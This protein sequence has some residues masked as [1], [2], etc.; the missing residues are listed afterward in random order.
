MGPQSLSSALHLFPSCLPGPYPLDV[1]EC[2]VSLGDAATCDHYCH[3]YLGG[4]YCSCRAGYVL[5][6]NKHTCSGEGE[7]HPICTRF[8]QL[9]KQELGSSVPSNTS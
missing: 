1:D 8:F 6:Q 3:N 7:G 2:R 5:H 4:Y 9:P